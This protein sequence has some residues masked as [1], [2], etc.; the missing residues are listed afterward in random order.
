MKVNNI[1]EK[2]TNL[3]LYHAETGA[4]LTS[5]ST[6]DSFPGSFSL[7]VELDLFNIK[8]D[9][10]YQILV[11]IQGEE[12]SEPILVHASNVNLPI[13]E[14]SVYHDSY[15]IATGSFV[16][17]VTPP[18]PGSYE[19]TFQLQEQDSKEKLGDFKQYLYISER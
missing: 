5:I 1:R 3:K 12:Q 16:F 2:I 9:K 18:A 19:L 7:V 10:K 8:A 14:F 15:G 17:S 13:S 11:S 4:L 6:L